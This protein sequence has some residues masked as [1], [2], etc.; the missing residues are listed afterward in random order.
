MGRSDIFLKLE[1]IKKILGLCVLIPT[2]FIS[3]KAMA[4]STV[5]TSIC[6]QIINSWPNRKLLNYYYI[7]QLWDILPQIGLSCAMGGV[8][9]CIYFMKLSDVATILIQ[10][11]LGILIYCIGS[12]MLDIDSFEYV[13][14]LAK[15]YTG[16]G[17]KS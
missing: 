11:P 1:I 14:G 10:V 12:K 8:V 5:F 6:S 9:Y 4:L 15:S 13:L 3:V 17:A 2:A 7:D 16:R